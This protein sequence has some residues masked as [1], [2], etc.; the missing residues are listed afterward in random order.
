MISEYKFMYVTVRCW[1]V[2]LCETKTQD[3][4][5]MG[6]FHDSPANQVPAAGSSGPLPRDSKRSLGPLGPVG[7][8]GSPRLK[9]PLFLLASPRTQRPPPPRND[10][11]RPDE[12]PSARPPKRPRARD[13][14]DLLD[15]EVRVNCSLQLVN[16]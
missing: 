10:A 16:A 9:R 5:S 7:S 6:V 12:R 13:A 3:Y 15:P 14:R 8:S 1:S 2:C 11:P 4:T